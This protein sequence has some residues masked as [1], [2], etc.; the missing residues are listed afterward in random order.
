MW[1][2]CGIADSCLRYAQHLHPVRAG[3]PPG[4]D[5]LRQVH[6]FAGPYPSRGPAAGCSAKARL[7]EQGIRFE[8]QKSNCV[9]CQEA[10]S[11][12]QGC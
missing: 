8:K 2:S 3:S 12:F 6:V 10:R 1:V 11:G 7:G 4:R 5:G 9:G